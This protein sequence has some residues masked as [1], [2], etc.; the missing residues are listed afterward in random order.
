MRGTIVALHAARKKQSASVQAVSVATVLGLGHRGSTDRRHG[1]GGSH[2]E[3]LD[4]VKF[5]IGALADDRT[6][7][8]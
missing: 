1:Q 4:A 3:T 2:V 7:R 5:R 8:F 6:V